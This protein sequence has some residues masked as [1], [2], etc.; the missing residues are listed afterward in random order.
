[1]DLNRKGSTLK[2]NKKRDFFFCVVLFLFEH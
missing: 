2:I 1:M